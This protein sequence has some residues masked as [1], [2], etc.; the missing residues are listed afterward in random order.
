VP[1]PR[2]QPLA[3]CA[4]HCTALH[5]T[6]RNAFAAKASVPVRRAPRKAARSAAA[7][8]RAVCAGHARSGARLFTLRCGKWH[9]VTLAIWEHPT[10]HSRKKTA[11]LLLG[12]FFRLLASGHQKRL[13]TVKRSA[14]YS[15]S[16][17][18]VGGKNL[19]KST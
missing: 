4:L 16:I 7:G 12:L 10:Q 14:F 13:R 18:F 19:R 2:C 5:C 3:A 9:P 11:L 6:H 1:V 17:K 8:L 15:A